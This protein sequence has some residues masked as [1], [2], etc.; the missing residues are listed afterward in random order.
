[1]YKGLIIL[2]QTKE[3]GGESPHPKSMFKYNLSNLF[4]FRSK[5][6]LSFTFKIAEP[7]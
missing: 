1:M 6:E 2:K 7:R 4:L 5:S 3:G